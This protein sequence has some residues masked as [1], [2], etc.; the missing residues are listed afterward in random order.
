MTYPMDD[1]SHVHRVN[2]VVSAV[3]ARPEGQKI[4]IRKATP[5]HQLHNGGWKRS[6]HRVDVSSLD[7]VLGFVEGID[8]AGAPTLLAVCEGQVTM[9]TLVRASMARGYIP[10]VVPEFPDFTVAGL[11]NG[12]GIQ[13]S[14]F[15]YGTFTHTVTELEVVLG[16]GEVRRVSKATDLELFTF[17]LE[18]YGSMAIVTAAV[19]ALRPCLPFVRTQYTAFSDLDQFITAFDGAVRSQMGDFL[20]GIVYGR[21]C[22]VLIS[23]S[24]AS[25]Q[26]NMRQFDPKPLDVE[27]GEQYYYQYIRRVVLGGD[28]RNFK[29]GD[30]ASGVMRPIDVIPTES[31]VFRSSRGLYWMLETHINMD[32]MMKY[33]WFRRLLD[34]KVCDAMKSKGFESNGHLSPEES[35]RC[36]VQQD[37]GIMLK[38]LKEGIE[39]VENRLGVYPLWLCPV[40]AKRSLKTAP[41]YLALHPEAAKCM[42]DEYV[43]DIGVYGEPTVQPF[44]HRR[45]VRALQEFVDAPSMWGV[46]YKPKEELVAAWKP[47]RD[48]Y[49]ATDVFVGVEQKVTFQ[50]EESEQLLN[51]G[52]IFAWRLVDHHGW[53]WW[54][55]LPLI[56][57]VVL[58]GV[59]KVIGVLW[60]YCA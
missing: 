9:M 34:R 36:V 35:Q 25:S 59:A 8:R 21:R 39:W 30:P 13:S 37:M 17:V 45:I 31:F 47:I 12:D 3:K 20:E 43:V 49:H 55:K 27:S 23:S 40:A 28:S 42:A 58:Y 54:L 24:F 53:Y 52:P 11:V 10:Q 22:Y 56:A 41:F 16:N 29:A 51:E 5:G 44:H 32:A 7:N 50:G 6:C 18:S 46:C 2:A 48:K 33:A 14:A 60:A 15:R 19:V 26:E 57:A 1:I 4:S 38:R